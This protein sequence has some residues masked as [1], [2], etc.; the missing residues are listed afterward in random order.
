MSPCCSACCR[1][2]HW[3]APGVSMEQY[4]DDFTDLPDRAEQL[5]A[6]VVA[7]QTGAQ[8]EAAG[9]AV[10]GGVGSHGMAAQLGLRQ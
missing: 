7:E 10:A 5:V 3:F 6:E 1:Y 2:E 4:A 8:A 9:D